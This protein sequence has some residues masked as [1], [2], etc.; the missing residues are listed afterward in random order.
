MLANIVYIIL[1]THIEG[2]LRM[3]ILTNL[4]LVLLLSFLRFFLFLKFLQLLQSFGVFLQLTRTFHDPLAPCLRERR[5]FTVSCVILHSETTKYLCQIS[6]IFPL[7]INAKP[8]G[9]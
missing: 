9:N 2:E 5:F 8:G 3:L 7:Q 6:I 1:Y 4:S